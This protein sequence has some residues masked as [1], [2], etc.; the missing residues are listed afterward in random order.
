MLTIIVVSLVLFVG[1]GRLPAL[2]LAMVCLSAFV[3][4]E[5]ALLGATMGAWVMAGVALLGGAKWLQSPTF[6]G[7]SKPVRVLW[8]TPRF[9]LALAYA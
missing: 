7:E 1:V 4:M 9:T 6:G 3:A 8:V 5:P 2:V